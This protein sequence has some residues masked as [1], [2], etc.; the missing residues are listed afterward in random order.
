MLVPVEPKIDPKLKEERLQKPT[1]A[2]G[3]AAGQ[4]A[5]AVVTGRAVNGLVAMAHDPGYL[6]GPFL[7]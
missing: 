5:V 7:F 6:F 4:V 1:V 2:P 3:R